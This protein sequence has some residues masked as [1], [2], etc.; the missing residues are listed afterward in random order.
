MT[1]EESW[2]IIDSAR[3]ESGGN[4]DDRLRILT[5]KLRTLPPQEILEFAM[6]VSSLLDEAYRADLWAA[7][8]IILGGCSDDTFL[9][10]REWLISRGQVAF[11]EC[12]ADAEKVGYWQQGEDGIFFEGGVSCAAYDAFHALTGCDL[13]DEIRAAHVIRPHPKLIGAS[14]DTDPV[15]LSKR[16]PRLFARFWGA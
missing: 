6:V 4:F 3:E 2:H 14:V 7:A 8:Y 5:R 1:H 10:F 11:R 12:V 13:W 15:A 9:D 16:L